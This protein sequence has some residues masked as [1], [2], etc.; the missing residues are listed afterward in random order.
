MRWIGYYLA[1]IGFS[2]LFPSTLLELHF[3]HVHYRSC[4][5]VDIILVLLRKSQYVKRR[6]E[7]GQS[8][9]VTS[10][11]I[12]HFPPTSPLNICYFLISANY[13]NTRKIEKMRNKIDDC[14]E[15]ERLHQWQ[16]FPLHHQRLEWL[17]FPE[18]QSG[19]HE[20]YC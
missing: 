6:L 4:D 20:C 5:S 11:C 12:H 10:N 9:M 3:S 14:K 16:T 13:G 15:L 19:N 1:A 2:L 7:K 8:K 18:T 17:S